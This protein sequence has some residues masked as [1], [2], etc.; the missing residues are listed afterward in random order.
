M[1]MIYDVS[2]LINEDI[3]VYKNK[4]EKKPKIDLVLNYKNNNC[5]ESKIDMN[6]HTGTHIDA[7]FHMV[8]NGKTVE[9]IKLENL[10]RKCKVFDFSKVENKITADDLMKKEIEENDFILLKTKNSFEDSF[11]FEF[12]FL[13]KSGAKYLKEKKISGVGIDA[14]GIERAQKDHDTHKI[15][16]TNDIIILEGLRLKDIKEGIYEMY[17]LPLKLEKVDGAP[18]RVILVDNR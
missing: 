13:E 5:N 6:L 7:P 9:S 18:A 14:L 1:K 12:V 3:Q 10:V 8:D 15:L 11:N 16:L 2:M 17:A 4:P